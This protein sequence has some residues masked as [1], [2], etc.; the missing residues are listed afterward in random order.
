MPIYFEFLIL[1]T[2]K[3]ILN[4]GLWQIE[5][6]TMFVAKWE[7]GPI[8]EKHELTTAPIW[9]EFRNVSHQFFP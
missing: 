4:Q 7:P 8:L 2:R 3:K 6:Q 1:K 5:G 9:V